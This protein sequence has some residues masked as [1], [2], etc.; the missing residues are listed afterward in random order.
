MW[1]KK[2]EDWIK[3]L[4]N[5]F[6]EEYKEKFILNNEVD[7]DGIIHLLILKAF[8]VDLKISY[9]DLNDEHTVYHY[10]INRI[11]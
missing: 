6:I 8:K 10:Y 4:H 9:L 1:G 3:E 5:C 7:A 11:V 2:L